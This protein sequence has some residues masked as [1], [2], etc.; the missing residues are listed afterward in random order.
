MEKVKVRTEK[1]YYFFFI[2]MRVVTKKVYIF[3]DV[4]WTSTAR[5]VNVL[6]MDAKN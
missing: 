6:Y 3:I 2:V 4:T 1:H 5:T